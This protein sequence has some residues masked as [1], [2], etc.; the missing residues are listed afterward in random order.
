[1]TWPKVGT[2]VHVE[3][4]DPAIHT[5]CPVADAKPA[6]C[7]TEGTIVKKTPVYVVVA[8]SQYEDGDGDFTVLVKGSCTNITRMI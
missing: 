4:L 1:M 8:A 5:M 3:W 6:K 2:R 7:W